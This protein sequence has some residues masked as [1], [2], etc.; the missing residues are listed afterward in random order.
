MGRLRHIGKESVTTARQKERDR[1]VAGVLAPGHGEFRRLAREKDAE[2]A[3]FDAAF[4]GPGLEEFAALVDPVEP[5]AEAGVVLV[6]WRVK[7]KGQ[8]VEGGVARRRRCREPDGP[9]VE[10]PYDE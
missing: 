7:R 3:G 2:I 10:W 1:R 4:L 5:F 8:P 6:G 9:F